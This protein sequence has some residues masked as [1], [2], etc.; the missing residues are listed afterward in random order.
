MGPGRGLRKQNVSPFCLLSAVGRVLTAM[1][2]V[3]VPD[4]DLPRTNPATWGNDFLSLKP[5]FPHLR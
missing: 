2:Q 3:R 1:G 4:K 5:P